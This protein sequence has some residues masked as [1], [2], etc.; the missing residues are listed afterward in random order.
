MSDIKQIYQSLQVS[1]EEAEEDDADAIERV[2]WHQHRGMDQS[3]PAEK[4]QPELV[5]LNMP[6]DGELDW[7]EMEFLIKWKGQSYMHC[8]W[9]SLSELQHVSCKSIFR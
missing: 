1:I 6:M 3:R 9:Q 2:L 8:Q 7:S 5:V 4:E